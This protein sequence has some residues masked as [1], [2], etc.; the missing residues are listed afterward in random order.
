MTAVYSLIICEITYNDG[1]KE[2]ELIT[3]E[4]YSVLFASVN[5]ISVMRDLMSSRQNVNRIEVK[6]VLYFKTQKD[7]ENYM[8]TKK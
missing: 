5:T 2:I 7:Y 3:Y 6:D 1:R 8:S 4:E